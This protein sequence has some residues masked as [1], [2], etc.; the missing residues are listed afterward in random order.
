MLQLQRYRCGHQHQHHQHHL[1]QQAHHH[2]ICLML[3]LLR[4]RRTLKREGGSGM[5]TIWLASEPELMQDW[6]F[7]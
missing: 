4:R 1:I 5:R 7:F 6:F 3:W 2:S